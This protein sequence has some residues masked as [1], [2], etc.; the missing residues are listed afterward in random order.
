M[1]RTCR[2]VAVTVMVGLTLL[3]ASCSSGQRAVPAKADGLP[4]CLG[5]PQVRPAL[6]DVN[7]ADMSLTARHLAWSGWGTPVATA[8]G[9]AV[10]DVC[11]YGDCYQGIYDTFP[12]VLVASGAQTCLNGKRDY[13]SLQFLF[14][15]HFTA[16]PAQYL[17][18]VVPRPCS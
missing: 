13:A 1:M 12:V 9:S 7:C 8:T 11:E 5:H 10:I 6:V 15:G 16:W 18:R 14:V 2:T 17:H 4:D 3:A